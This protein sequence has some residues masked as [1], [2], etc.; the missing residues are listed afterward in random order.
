MVLPVLNFFALIA[1]HKELQTRH[2]QP[3]SLQQNDGTRTPTPP[4]DY[5]D[6]IEDSVG[7][8]ESSAYSSESE[9]TSNCTPDEESNSAGPLFIMPKHKAQ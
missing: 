5:A 4:V 9:K 1:S 6:N 3:L 8:D 2:Q 7:D